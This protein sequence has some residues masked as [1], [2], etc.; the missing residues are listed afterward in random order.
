MKS[1]FLLVALATT[2]ATG[3]SAQNVGIGT[4]NPQQKLHIAGGLRIDTLS[5]GMDSGLLRHDANGTVFTLH[6]PGD[7]TQVL[8][9]DGTFGKAHHHTDKDPW[10][11]LGN[12]GTSSDTNFI[13]TTDSTDL[14]FRINNTWAG[15]L[16]FKTQSTF[17][18]YQ[19]GQNSGTASNNTAVGFQALPSASGGF[20][21]AVGASTLSANS[22]G[23]SNVAVGF[24]ALSRNTSGEGN[25]AMGIV[26]LTNNL[27]GNG[28]VAIGGSSMEFSTTAQLNTAVGSAT[29]A[30][31]TTGQQNTALGYQAEMLTGDLNNATA[32][33]AGALVDASNKVR[34]GNVSV[35]VIEGQVLPTTPSDGRYKFNIREDI[36]GLDF[37]LRLRPVSYQFDVRRFDEA[38]RGPS[39]I[40]NTA[41]SRGSSYDEATAMRRTGFIAQ[42]VEK[43]A[44]ECGYDFTGVIRP[45]NSMEHYGLSYEAFI[46]PMV[47]AIQEQQRQIDDLKK[48]VADQQQMILR[49]INN[50]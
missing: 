8:R 38:M 2:V 28:N 44:A 45:S 35:T 33:G 23:N 11:L 6:F 5:N 29:F 42:E 32:L 31:L 25:I 49:L 9:G 12:A 18:G 22:T 36:K 50:K 13:G 10:L 24:S 15:K 43:A 3:A 47:K 16:D 14:E 27:G 30:N 19:A 1:T 17:F 37:I 4:T 41:Y 7:S 48:M 21:T 26:A 34:I 20:N 39:A 40:R 46:M